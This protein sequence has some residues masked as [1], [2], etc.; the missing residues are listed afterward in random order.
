MTTT[1]A[2]VGRRACLDAG[3]VRDG[4]GLQDCHDDWLAELAATGAPLSSLVLPERN[5]V[6]RLLTRLGC[7]PADATAVAETLP[8]PERDPELWWL[9]ERCCQRLTGDMGG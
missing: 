4:L 3:R 9:L 8:S 1:R 2:A 7:R 6:T 5:Q